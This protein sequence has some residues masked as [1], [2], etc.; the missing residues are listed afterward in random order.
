MYRKT[1]SEKEFSSYI[2]VIEPLASEFTYVAE[3]LPQ[4]FLQAGKYE[5]LIDIALSNTLLPTKNPI[6]T[7]NVMVYRLQ[8]AFKAALRAEKYGDAIKLALRAGE[9]VAGDQRQQI[10]FLNNIDLLPKLQ[11]NLKVQEIA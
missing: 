6:D 8:F 9:E 1:R 3:V 10:L 5:E 7:R 2:K 4:L 11:D